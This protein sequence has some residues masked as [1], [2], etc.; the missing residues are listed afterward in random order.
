MNRNQEYVKPIWPKTWEG[1]RENISNNLPSL[2]MY[3]I[4]KV[5]MKPESQRSKNHIRIMNGSTKDHAACPRLCH[6]YWFCSQTY[7]YVKFTNDEDRHVCYVPFFHEPW[8]QRLL[9][10]WRR[11]SQWNNGGSIKKMLWQNAFFD[12]EEFHP[13]S[14]TYGE[15]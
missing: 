10:S 13:V 11:K 6:F 4:Y 2:P 7:T 3:Q 5:I 15:T 14:I 9:T 1:D 8:V 12:H